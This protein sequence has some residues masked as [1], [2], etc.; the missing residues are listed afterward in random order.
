MS[1]KARRAGLNYCVVIEERGAM[2]GSGVVTMK[3]G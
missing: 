2:L 3:L 1:S